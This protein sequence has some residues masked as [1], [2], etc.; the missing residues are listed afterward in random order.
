MKRI[1]PY[2]L[3]AIVLLLAGGAFLQIRGKTLDLSFPKKENSNPTVMSEEGNGQKL[4]FKNYGNAP[5]FKGITQW[6]NSDPQTMASFKGKVILIDFWTYSCINCIRT[7]PYINKWYETYKDQGFV[8]IGVHT[9]EFQFEK[10]TDNVQTA[11]Q[12]FNIKYPVAQD[13]NYA[14]WGAYNNQFWPAKYL[15][16]KEGKIVYQ[17]FGEGNYELTETAIRQLIGLP[18]GFAT[19]EPPPPDL[20]KIKSPEMYFGLK[21][22]EF[23]ANKE[24]A[25]DQE[26]VYTLPEKLK[27][28]TYALEGVWKLDQEKA[29]LTQGYG[30]IRL[31]FNSGKVH[32]VAQS[33]KPV[34]LKVSVDGKAQKEVTVQ[35]S[36]LYTLFNSE[37]YKGH[38][39]DI[40][41]PQPGFE[42]FTFTFG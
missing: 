14:T 35:A 10:A 22:V 23:M 17:H 6:L 37:E 18:G 15:I 1:L 8:V 3:I 27:L 39:I 12:R 41:I 38:I 33:I 16:D 40:E 11:I 19:N 9:P 2:I 7:L 32:M 28:N 42:A 34:T 24:K 29:V 4:E 5:E 25:T 20:S 13:N 21:R 26:Q 31:S 30:R 36:Q